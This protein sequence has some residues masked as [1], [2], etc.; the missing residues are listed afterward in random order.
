VLAVEFHTTAR[1]DRRV[2]VN[3]RALV[4]ARWSARA[5]LART[6]EELDRA[7]S[8]TGFAQAGDTL[9]GPIES[10]ENGVDV[11][12]VILDARARLNL[13]RAARRDL[14]RLLDALGAPAADAQRL[15]DAIRA[16]PLDRVDELRSLPGMSDAAYARIAPHVTVVGDGRVNVN[17]ASV[18]VLLTLPGLN[19]EAATLIVGRRAV[20]PYR[21]IFELI[22]S[23][24]GPTQ[25]RV[26]TR[27]AELV[28]RTAFSPRTVEIAVVATAREPAVKT[29]LIATVLL[30][31][32]QNRSILR[33]IER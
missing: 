25:T 11:R 28:D 33:T 15:A 32:G 20:A 30:G 26:Q 4:Q 24:P 31:G 10:A 8:S 21:S 27:L 22:G 7:L 9:I 3:A 29:E 18:P 14:E 12:G 2:A 5:G 13:N 1:S 23:L 16:A 6:L 19:A 17:S